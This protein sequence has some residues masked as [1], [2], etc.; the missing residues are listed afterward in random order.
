M[1][2]K[3]TLGELDRLFEERRFSE[4]ESFLLSK[5]NEAETENDSSSKLALLNE[6]LG[7]N[8]SLHRFKESIMLAAKIITLMKDMGIEEGIPYATSVLNIATVYREAGKIDE[9]MVYYNDVMKIYEKTLPKNDMKFASLYNNMSQAYIETNDYEK[10][11]DLLEKALSIVVQNKGTEVEEAVTNSNLGIALMKMNK[12]A[13][14][15]KHIE[16][17]LSI[18]EK[19]ADPK[20]FHY[21]AALSAMGE[22]QLAL[23]NYEK[24]LGY[25]NRA[26]DEI[27]NSMGKSSRY[28]IICTKIS[29][30]YGLLNNT[31]QKEKYKTIADA[32]FNRFKE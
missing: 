22:L 17:S 21:S 14:A 15:L 11:C 29:L 24:A 25:F 13:D 32:I 31:V 16:K 6:L 9:A 19:K 23:K 3:K 4:V 7:F 26:L 10:A 20:D 18:F 27:E 28:A 12:Q 1:E 5:I 8:R 2:I 30:V